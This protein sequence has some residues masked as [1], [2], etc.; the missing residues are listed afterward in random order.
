M[1]HLKWKHLIHKKEAAVSQDSSGK[2]K[3]AASSRPKTKH[4]FLKGQF[5]FLPQTVDYHIKA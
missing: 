4:F 1:K 3:Q 5:P 2:R